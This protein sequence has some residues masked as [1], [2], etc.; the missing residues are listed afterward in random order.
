[1][2][3][4]LLQSHPA[5]VSGRAVLIKACIQEE[6]VSKKIRFGPF[7][8]T[9]NSVCIIIVKQE[10]ITCQVFS[11]R[12]LQRCVH[13]GNARKDLLGLRRLESPSFS[14]YKNEKNK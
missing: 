4:N 10:E 8:I 6:S 9:F 2:S 3:L 14:K 7:F 1:M 5:V 13:P 11:K 12:L